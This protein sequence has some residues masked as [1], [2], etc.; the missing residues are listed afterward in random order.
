MLLFLDTVNNHKAT[1]AVIEG[2][3]ILSRLSFKV[4]RD[5][6]EKLLP[7]IKRMLSRHGMDFHDI[8][9]IAVV[10]GPGSYT[11]VRTGVAIANALAYALKKPILGLRTDQVPPSLSQLFAFNFGQPPVL[12]LYQSPPHITKPKKR[13]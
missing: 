10:S 12:P 9:R 8:S 5:I 11:G 6:S 4:N 1:V 13:F 2:R 7:A 3:K